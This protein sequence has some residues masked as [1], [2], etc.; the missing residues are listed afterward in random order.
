MDNR[1]GIH[2]QKIKTGSEIPIGWKKGRNISKIKTK[3][4]NRVSNVVEEFI[5]PLSFF[6]DKRNKILISPQDIINAFIKNDYN[7]KKVSDTNSLGIKESTLNHLRKFY[8]SIGYETSI[9]K[10]VLKISKP[11]NKKSINETEKED[12][13]NYY[14][15]GHGLT[16]CKK[17]FNH[18]LKTIK[19]LLNVDSSW[20]NIGFIN[21]SGK[22]TH[23]LLVNEEIKR[24]ILSNGWKLK[25]SSVSNPLK[26][27]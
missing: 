4:L 7:W 22:Y 17:A 13:L 15:Q 24:R 9:T 10:P 20:K 26:P 1:R 25:S 8:E 18:S 21:D 19:N 5:L 27:L 3:L 6:K 16:E 12:I 2:S 14:C 11:E 23:L